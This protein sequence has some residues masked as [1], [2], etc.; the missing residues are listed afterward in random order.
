MTTAHAMLRDRRHWRGETRSLGLTPD[1]AL[2]LMR[3]PAP[4]DGKA[5]EVPTAYPCPRE[6]SGLAF[7]PGG[8]LFVADTAHDRILYIDAR[9]SAQAWLPRADAHPRN[10]PG[11]FASP[12]GLAVDADGLWVADRGNDRL[13][14]LAFPGLEPNLAHAVRGPA[15]I[16]FDA[17]ARLLVIGGAPPRLRRILPGG[18]ADDAFGELIARAPL[19]APH[20]VAVSAT[21]EL[22][23]SDTMTNTVS[24]FN[25]DG[26]FIAT[27]AGPTGWLP[28]AV[29]CTGTRTYVADASTGRI[30]VFEHRSLQGRIESF[31]GPVTALAVAADRALFVKPG[32][33]ERTFLLTNDHA[34][35]SEGELRAGPFDA[36][37]DQVWE[38]A[39]M[40]AA[41][42]S[43]AAL[44]FEVA[45]QPVPIEPAPSAWRT[46]PGTDALLAQPLYESGRFA[47]V[48]VKLSSTSPAVTPLVRQVRFA[49]AAED[50][51]DYLPLT[52]RLN[53]RDAF[54]SRWLKLVR[55]EFGRIEEAIDLLSRLS[56]PEFV[57]PAAIEW[58]AQWLGMELPS[59]ADEAQR[60]GL[61]AQALQRYARRGTPRSIADFVELHTGI[62]PAIVEAFEMRRSWVLGVS[63]RLDFDTRLPPLSPTGMVVPDPAASGCCPGPIGSAVV[64]ASGPLASYQL[65]VP[66]F[67]DEAYRFCVVTDAY[68]VREP[69]VLDELQRIVEREK[70]AH[71]DYRVELIVPGLRVGFQSRIGIETVIGDAARSVL[72]QALLGFD[73]RLAAG[74]VPRVGNALL[75]ST[76]TL[77]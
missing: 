42:P 40:D 54:L 34:H 58:L 19:T 38:R 61:I 71:T 73:S 31:R 10:A 30:L 5:I 35:A 72:D 51:M 16:A 44:E 52:Y 15:A 59:L 56:D 50:F 9:C 57:P 36:G 66:L 3:I 20:A 29:A 8:S 76:L 65:G 4:V 74:D 1:G 77:S 17:Q 23:V 53:D 47:W 7:G 68:R 21:G 2:E 64:G 12:C 45:L 70:P 11:H 13:Q 6:R 67:A 62:R 43:A 22:L 26:S 24:V 41:V 25:S 46:I 39:W 33:D 18:Q 49:T 69:G 27:L 55:G 75:G 28:G 32:L 48:R 63:S 37:E 60:R 14:H